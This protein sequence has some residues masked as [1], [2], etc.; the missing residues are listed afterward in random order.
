MSGVPIL[1]AASVGLRPLGPL[2]A[3]I[4]AG[5]LC[6]LVAY[7]IGASERRHWGGRPPTTHEY[8]HGKRKMGRVQYS[9]SQW[10]PRV[11]WVALAA[12]ALGL[13][14]FAYGALA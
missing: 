5:S 11:L 2:G 7:F 1:L 4:L 3:G 10:S 9:T 6:V 8:L 14:L 12:A 13:A